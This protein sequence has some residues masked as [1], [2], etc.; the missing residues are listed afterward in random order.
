MSRPGQRD[1]ILWVVEWWASGWMTSDKWWP[2]FFDSKVT[3]AD[4]REICKRGREYYPH[5]KFRLRKYVRAE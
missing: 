3:R 1:G 5:C 4:A 2:Y